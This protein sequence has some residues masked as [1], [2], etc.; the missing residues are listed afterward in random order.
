[1]SR[2]VPRHAKAPSP[3]AERRAEVLR[4]ARA[5]ARSGAIR[6]VGGAFG[7]TDA[8][9]DR[10]LMASMRLSGAWRSVRGIPAPWRRMQWCVPTTFWAADSAVRILVDLRDAWNDAMVI[11]GVAV[12]A[13]GYIAL[14]ARESLEIRRARGGTHLS[15]AAGGDVGHGATAELARETARELAALRSFYIR[16]MSRICETAGVEIPQYE[17]A[18]A[19]AWEPR[20]IHGGGGSAA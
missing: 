15:S 9:H 5:E 8:V 6:A 3:G 11:L 10:F 19:R 20:V 4:A 14:F 12:L 17:P 18:P 7:F 13:G 2:S 1:M 16:T